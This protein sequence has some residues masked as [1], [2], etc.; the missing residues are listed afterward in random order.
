MLLV[1]SCNDF[2]MMD[3]S[4]VQVGLA[5]VS[6]FFVILGYVLV[7]ENPLQLS[8]E[9]EA[10][11]VQ[12]ESMINHVDRYWF[13]QQD[14]FLFPS[15][16]SRFIAQISSEFIRVKSLDSSQ[17]QIVK[18]VPQIL[19]IS[20]ENHTLSS[21]VDFHQ[22]ILHLFGSEGTRDDPLLNESN[23]TEWFYSRYNETQ[24]HFHHHPFIW[25]KG[26]YITLEKCIIFKIN[27]NTE[28]SKQIPL[29]EFLII[30]KN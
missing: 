4:F 14:S 30:K 6:V 15:C 26:E 9:I 28:S 1:L 17:I 11:S 7:Y 23:V 20:S 22:E 5:I 13:E 21:S 3:V 10:V 29:I 8:S 2:A 18:S 25:S 12:I 19:W 16:K 27:N 24:Y